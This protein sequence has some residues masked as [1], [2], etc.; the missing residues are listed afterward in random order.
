MQNAKIILGISGGIAAYKACDLASL[1]VKEKAQVHAVLSESATKFI[2]PLALKT[3]TYNP[4]YSDQFDYDLVEPIH[5]ELCREASV[6]VLAPATANLIAKI[7]NGICDDLL[8]TIVCAYKGPI[9]VAPAMNTAMW[10]NPILQENLNKLKSK[11]NCQVVEPIEGELA[12]RTIGIGKLAPV[13]KILAAV[14][15]ILR[16]QKKTS[17]QKS[18]LNKIKVLITAGG[19]R[20][21]I[22]PVRFI[23]NRSSGK[24]GLALADE[25]YARGAEVTLVT[26]QKDLHKAY[27]VIEVETTHQMQESVESLFDSSQILI[28]AAAVSDFKPLEFSPSK[29]KKASTSEDWQLLLTKNPD[30][31][32]TLGRLKKPGQVIIGFA[33][34]SNNLVENARK[35]LEN[36]KLDLIVA[37]EI[38]KP[39][40]G[41]S[42]DYNEVY[43]LAQNSKEPTLL[44]KA[45][46][47]EISNQLWAY[48]EKNLLKS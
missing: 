35:K 33:A 14:Q 5:V 22:D 2:S 39:D 11:L 44:S 40:I 4:A 17:Q 36:K 8:S 16:P 9:V 3:I 34:E 48:I 24:M 45:T 42:S 37:N 1:L 27:K 10:E 18:K 41:F 25:A 32:A 28:M 30:I 20:E 21:A 26:T 46:K 12:C 29:I 23:G 43:L 15:D 6:L 38:N 47:C 31:L 7:A 19:T 13:E